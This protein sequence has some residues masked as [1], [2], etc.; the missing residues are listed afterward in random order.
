MCGSVIGHQLAVRI[1]EPIIT[2]KLE[3]PLVQGLEYVRIESSCLNR[4][5]HIVN[6]V[7]ILQHVLHLLSKIGGFVSSVRLGKAMLKLDDNF[8]WLTPSGLSIIVAGTNNNDDYAFVPSTQLQCICTERVF[9]HLCLS[10]PCQNENDDDIGDDNTPQ[11]VQL[12]KTSPQHVLHWTTPC[13]HNQGLW[14]ILTRSSD[15]APCASTIKNNKSSSC[16]DTLCFIVTLALLLMKWW[17]SLKEC[18]IR[19]FVG[20]C[21]FP[22]SCHFS[23]RLPASFPKNQCDV[24]LEECD[25]IG[26]RINVQQSL[27]QS[28]CRQPLSVLISSL[29]KYWEIIASRS[30]S[31][32]EWSSVMLA[33]KLR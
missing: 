1:E 23:S 13:Y 33:W 9:L 24:A 26:S 14:S 2:A 29:A 22:T 21:S 7:I 18:Y 3:G 11:V 31:P 30:T 32:P 6:K 12:S 28:Y 20:Q 8:S 17:K 25:I 10:S 16:V 5:F 4:L 27:S 15:S 19:S